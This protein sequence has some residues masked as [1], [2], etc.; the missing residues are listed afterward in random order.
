MGFMD[1]PGKR[2]TSRRA[3]FTSPEAANAFACAI[4]TEVGGMHMVDACPRP[5]A[6]RQ[7]QRRVGQ[8]KT[9]FVAHRVRLFKP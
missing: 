8:G 5:T 3:S 9:A 1:V 4:L 7:W 6:P 2:I